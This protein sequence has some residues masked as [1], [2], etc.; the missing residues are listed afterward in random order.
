MDRGS[1]AR[2]FAMMLFREGVETSVEA[3]FDALSDPRGHQREKRERMRRWYDNQT[4]E[5]QQTFRLV[6]GE[7]MVLAVFGIAVHLD[8]ATG[9]IQVGDRACE[10]S[11]A[12]Q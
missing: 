10:V 7:A 9:V 4:E 6:V 11:A 12:L 2:A 3:F 1:A 8:G 5:D